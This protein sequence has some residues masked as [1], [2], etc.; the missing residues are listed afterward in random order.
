MWNRFK[1]WL[2][3]H[4]GVLLS[5]NKDPWVTWAGHKGTEVCRSC[6]QYRRIL[7]HDKETFIVL[8]WVGPDRL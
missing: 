1:C 4:D 2:G 8:P 7:G 5:L 6:N 3:L